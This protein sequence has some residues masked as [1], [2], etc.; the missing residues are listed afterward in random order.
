[1]VYY[2]NAIEVELE[3]EHSTGALIAYL[4]G[5]AFKFCFIMFTVQCVVRE[6]AKNFEREKCTQGKIWTEAGRS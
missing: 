2:E 6:E 4:Y 5:E 3:G 1:M